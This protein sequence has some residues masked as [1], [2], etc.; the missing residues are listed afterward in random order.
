M[1]TE[2]RVKENRYEIIIKRLGRKDPVEKDI[3]GDRDSPFTL[4]TIY[5]A[6]IAFLR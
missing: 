6:H 1:R 2:S 4:L 5:V 3:M